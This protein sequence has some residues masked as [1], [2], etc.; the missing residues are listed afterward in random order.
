[1]LRDWTNT[2]NSCIY[3]VHTWL[4]PYHNKRNQNKNNQTK[5]KQKTDTIHSW[6]KF[7]NL[8]LKC[9]VKCTFQARAGRNANVIQTRNLAKSFLQERIFYFKSFMVFK[10]NTYI[11]LT[12]AFLPQ[13]IP[14]QDFLF[15]YISKYD[16]CRPKS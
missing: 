2:T 5:T 1:M 16:L 10:F 3:Q 9:Y 12:G 11:L 4:G 13:V 7:H 6:L 15:G 14:C 8:Y